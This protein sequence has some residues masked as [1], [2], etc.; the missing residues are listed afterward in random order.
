MSETDEPFEVLHFQG[1]SAAEL[2][3]EQLLELIN[4]A[5]DTEIETVDFDQF[6]A[7]A[8]QEQ[9]WFGEV[10]KATAQ[11]YR[12]L[13]AALKQNLTDLKVYRVGEVN[14]YIYVL[15]Q[16]KSGEVVGLGTKAVET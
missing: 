2:T 7:R 14:V 3:E 11:R 9:D 13:V 1:H 10:E 6:F 12:E 15:G 4:H 16:K 8:T 5:T